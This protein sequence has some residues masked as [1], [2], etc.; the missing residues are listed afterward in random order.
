MSSGAPLPAI[1]PPE[2]MLMCAA[3]PHVVEQASHSREAWPDPASPVSPAAQSGVVEE[4]CLRPAGFIGLLGIAMI[5]FVD[6][7]RTWKEKPLI[8]ALFLALIVGCVLAA[9]MLVR[10]P[11]RG[12]QAAGVLGALALVSYAVSR[13][14]GLPTSTSDI[15]NWAEPLGLAALF[16]EGMVVVMSIWAIA[17]LREGPG[18]LSAGPVRSQ[19][20]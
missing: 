6:L 7:P 14:W 20:R 5:H 2:V 11:R 13:T 15:G 19:Q 16:V 1:S 8:G 18:V 10:N 3:V 9:G 17:A 12:W 4:A